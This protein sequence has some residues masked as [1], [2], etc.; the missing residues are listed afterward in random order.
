MSEPANW[1][2]TKFVQTVVKLTPHCHD[3]TRLLSESMERPL[4]LRTRVLIRLHFSICVWC[5][6]YARHL[7]YLRKYS[8]EFSEKGCEHGEPTLTPGARERLNRA[9]LETNRKG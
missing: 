7:K 1:V 9:L 2:K 8:C 4:P 3:I 5:E 6:R